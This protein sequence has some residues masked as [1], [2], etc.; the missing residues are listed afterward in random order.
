MIKI[1]FGTPRTSSPTEK[2]GNM[3]VYVLQHSYECGDE[4]ICEETK[5]LG[6]FSTEQEA[7][8]AME[9]YKT[10][11]GFRDYPDDFYIDKYEV[12]KKYW[13]EGFITV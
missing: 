5:F 1:R 2:G 9:Y 4:L 6:V 8:K 12:D 7:K 3:T 11:E 13:S 10:L